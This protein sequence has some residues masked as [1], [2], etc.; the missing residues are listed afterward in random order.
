MAKI[1]QL[2][3]LVGCGY[4]SKYPTKK[5]VRKVRAELKKNNIDVCQL[6]KWPVDNCQNADLSKVEGCTA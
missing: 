4:R 1:G 3:S 6:K 2:L 5:I